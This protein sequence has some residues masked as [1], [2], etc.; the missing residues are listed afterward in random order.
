[1]G[2][3]FIFFFFFDYGYTIFPVLLVSSTELFYTFFKNQLFFILVNPF[4]GSLFHYVSVKPFFPS[5]GM[6]GITSLDIKLSGGHWWH[7]LWWEHKAVIFLLKFPFGSI[8]YLLFLWWEFLLHSWD[9]L[10]FHCFKPV[11]KCFLKH[12]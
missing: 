10:V 2:F 12:F 9:V 8:L 11:C 1:M 3:R 6:L 7:P 5:W 4:L